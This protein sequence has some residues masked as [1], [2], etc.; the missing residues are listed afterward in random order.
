MQERDARS[1]LVSIVIVNWNT[2]DLLI[3][4][5]R[6]IVDNTADVDYE[7]IV[8][9]NASADHSVEA[10][11]EAFPSV[12]V[13]ASAENLGFAAG[14]NLGIAEAAGDFL[15]LLNP[16]T[17][18]PA[19]TIRGLVDFLIAH[20]DVGV[21]GPLL[22]GDDGRTQISSFGLNP[23][24]LEAALRAA[25]IWRIAP[26][27]SL[28]RR[29]LIAPS[30][31]EPWTY[32]EHILGACMLLRT[33]D[34]RAIN[35]F[36][37]GFFLFLEE[38]DICF[39]IKQIGLRT[40]YFTGVSITHLGEQSMQGILDKTGALYIRSYNRFCR[41]HGIRGGRLLIVNLFLIIGALVESVVA[42]L[43]H[44]SLRRALVSLRALW[45]GYI[46]APQ[47]A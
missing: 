17:I 38:T 44:R 18:V 37:E 24:P 15:L 32:V 26:S 8:V 13:I 16:D 31:G 39:R 41:K 27:S 4:C 35:G 33:K 9:D 47:R 23:G 25:R 42:L 29:F 20:E 22:V 6:S 21:V 45:Y 10:V 11:R 3:E 7:I 5:I 2:R 40:A 36:D 28:A 14:N 43:K 34:M 12:K 1:E 19:G 46:V 30:E